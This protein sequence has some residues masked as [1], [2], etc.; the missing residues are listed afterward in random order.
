MTKKLFLHIG[1]EKTG[2]TTIQRFCSINRKRF[3]KNGLLYPSSAGKDCQSLLTAA[4]LPEEKRIDF[5]PR[6]NPERVRHAFK[7]ECKTTKAQAIVVSS[8]HLSSRFRS[9]QVAE[10]RAFIDECNVEP[11][12][13]VYLREQDDFLVSSY[14]T[15]VKGRC[16]LAIDPQMAIRN[17]HRYHYF[18]LL[19]RWAAHFPRMKVRIYEPQQLVGHDLLTDFGYAIE[20]RFERRGYML[21]ERQNKSLAPDLL[22][23]KRLANLDIWAENAPLKKSQKASRKLLSKLEILQSPYAG[24]TLITPEQ[25]QEILDS[26]ADS[27]RGVAYQ[28]LG[29]GG[30]LFASTTDH[31]RPVYYQF[32]DQDFQR[33]EQQ[34][35]SNAFDFWFR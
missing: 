28:Y 29:R 19:D 10:F 11:E 16:K 24:F 33:I 13:I 4:F 6:I 30:P 27:N 21:P 5:C 3:L 8:E 32:S 17:K 2:T 25:R 18:N 34:I 23:Y 14:S 22:E 31:D 15:A 1:T 26:Y 12:V 20:T 7:Q 35:A 9:E